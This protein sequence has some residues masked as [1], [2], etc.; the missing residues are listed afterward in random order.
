MVVR[1]RAGMRDPMPTIRDEG[2]MIK[3]L[4]LP[5]VPK[6][7]ASTWAFWLAFPGMGQN[8]R[9]NSETRC[10]QLYIK[11][12]V[13][14]YYKGMPLTRC[15]IRFICLIVI[16]H[17]SGLLFEYNYLWE[18]YELF[19]RENELLGK[20]SNRHQTFQQRHFMSFNI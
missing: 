1:E 7:R 18:I 15:R 19:I 17:I 9:G 5:L 12:I 6:E 10:Q 4:N 20:K 11:K 2:S 3:V 16:F 14:L 8:G 13:T